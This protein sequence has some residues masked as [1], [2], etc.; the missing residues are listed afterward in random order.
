MNIT[1]ATSKASAGLHLAQERMEDLGRAAGEKLDEARNETA[2]ALENAAS[3]V[4]TIETMSGTA[5]GKLDSTAAYVRSHDLGG[6]LVSLREVMGRHP[7][8]FIILAAGAGFL[9]GSAFRRNK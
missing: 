5:A 4:R 1:D 3:S 6:M 8:A 2:A 7:T 9:A